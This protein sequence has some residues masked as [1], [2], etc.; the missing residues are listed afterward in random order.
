MN[1]IER[2]KTDV[3][4]LNLLSKQLLSGTFRF[5]LALNKATVSLWV[6]TG[7]ERGT[8]CVK[9]A[10]LGSCYQTGKE[11]Y[12]TV[13]SIIVQLKH[14]YKNHQVTKPQARSFTT[15]DSFSKPTLYLPFGATSDKFGT[16]EGVGNSSGQSSL[17]E[18]DDALRCICS[19]ARGRR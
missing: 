2:M 4:V 19:L 14:G 5:D 17:L 8:R 16:R 13:L 7:F 11:D 1:E 10:G 18:V 3:W 6:G 12:L 9:E 15:F